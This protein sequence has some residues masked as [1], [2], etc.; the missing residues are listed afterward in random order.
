VWELTKSRCIKSFSKPV[1]HPDAIAPDGRFALSGGEGNTLLLWDLGTGRLVRTF[2]KALPSSASGAA[3]TCACLSLDGR[4]ALTGHKSEIKETLRLWEIASGKCLRVLAGEE[5]MIMAPSN[6]WNDVHSV[7]FTAD[8]RYA[9]SGS[10]LFKVKLWELSSGR[11]LR[12]FEG[13]GEEVRSVACALDGHYALSGS[14]DSTLKQWVLDWELEDRP[15]ADWDDGARPHLESF[16]VLQTPRPTGLQALASVVAR[17][18]KP[19][20]SE[21][22]FKRLLYTL[23]CAGFGWLRPEGVRRKLEEMAANWQGPPPLPGN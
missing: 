3:V 23:G 9:L 13:H 21:E 18:P 8:G 15:P 4:Y 7:A 22:D 6:R 11:C 20:W 1:F 10:G 17:R 16:L 12:S 2:E 14:M 5:A 19:A